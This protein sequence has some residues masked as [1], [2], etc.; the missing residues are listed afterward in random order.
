MYKRQLVGRGLHDYLHAVGE[1]PLGRAE[2]GV[3]CRFLYG[4]Y[5]SLCTN[6]S[7]PNSLSVERNVLQEISPLYFSFH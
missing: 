6:R 3:L 2:R 7:D 5:P 1:R 4:G